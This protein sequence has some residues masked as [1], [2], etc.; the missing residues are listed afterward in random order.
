MAKRSKLLWKAT[1]VARLFR[2]AKLANVNLQRVEVD[3]DG[4]LVGIVG[5]QEPQGGGNDWDKTA[6]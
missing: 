1:D 4:R 3:R 6:A 5:E 2:A